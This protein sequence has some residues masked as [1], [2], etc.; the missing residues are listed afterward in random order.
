MQAR[1]QTIHLTEIVH[2][3]RRVNKVKKK[4]RRKNH[5]CLLLLR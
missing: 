1:R 5:R 3:S 2:P 4:N